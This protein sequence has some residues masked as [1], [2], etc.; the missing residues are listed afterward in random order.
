M[1]LRII[2]ILL[3]I[4]YMKAVNLVLISLVFFCGMGQD[5]NYDNNGDDWAFGDCAKNGNKGIIKG[6]SNHLLNYQRSR[7]LGFQI[8]T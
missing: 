3:I 5:Y 2:H 8:R 4:L 1:I 7:M 6:L